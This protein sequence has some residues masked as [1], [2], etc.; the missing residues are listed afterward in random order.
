MLIFLLACTHAADSKPSDTSAGPT[1]S[2]DTQPADTDTGPVDNE[3][4]ELNVS[5]VEVGVTDPSEPHAIHII[6]KAASQIGV[7]DSNFA[8]GCC[9][10]AEVTATADIDTMV[11]T[12]VYTLTG[13]DCDCVTGLELSYTLTGLPTGRW[14]VTY[15]DASS[16]ADVP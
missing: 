14:T 8:Q 7:I 2:G 11:V 5:A 9:P 10:Q 12:P 1:D 4:F 13:D 6:V 16:S 15:G 3:P